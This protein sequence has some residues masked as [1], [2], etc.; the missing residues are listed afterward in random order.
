MVSTADVT[1]TPEMIWL[2]LDEVK[3]PE[4]P[5]VSVVDLGIIRSV[6]VSD[7]RVI[8]T[9]TPTFAGCP[10]LHVMQTE[11]E[12][13]LH[14]MLALGAREVEVRLVLSPRWTSNWITGAARARLQA[15]G[16][17]PPPRHTGDLESALA[18]PVACPFCGSSDTEQ[19]ND[20]GS[21]LCRA[22]YVCRHCRQPFERFKPL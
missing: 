4:I 9:M 15:F 10:A 8:V 12:A 14:A 22:I 17:A 19:T 7:E 2:A 11:I 3:D 1:L 16:L 20:F 13:R 21:T 6:A 5:V 18:G